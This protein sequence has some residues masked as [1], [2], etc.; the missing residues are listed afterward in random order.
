[1]VDR[2]DDP[3]AHCARVIGTGGIREH[4]E[5][6]PIVMLQ[7]PGHQ[8]RRRMLVEIAGY[9]ADAQSAAGGGANDLPD[10]QWRRDSG[11]KIRAPKSPRIVSAAHASRGRTGTKMASATASGRNPGTETRL[12]LVEARPIQHLLLA[13]DELRQRAAVARL[14]RQYRAHRHRRPQAGRWHGRHPRL[15]HCQRDRPGGDPAPSTR[16]RALKP[17]RP[18]RHRVVR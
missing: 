8:P 9:V 10:P 12:Q 5:S 18:I 15:F 6:H 1:M 3:R 17:S 11:G 13:E 2:R 14:G 16:F 4:L 7:H